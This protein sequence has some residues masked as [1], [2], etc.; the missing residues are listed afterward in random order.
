MDIKKNIIIVFAAT[1]LSGCSSVG[2]MRNIEPS[3]YVH[4]TDYLNDA[5]E[6]SN[7][8]GSIFLSQGR[9]FT[10][11]DGLKY[12][13][14][15]PNVRCSYDSIEYAV[16]KYCAHKGGKMVQGGRW[17]K[18]N[19]EPLF[20]INYDYDGKHYSVS[21]ENFMAVE[22]GSVQG[23][24]QWLSVAERLGFLS[25]RVLL[26]QKLENEINAKKEAAELQRKTKE[27]NTPVNADVGDLICKEDYEAKPYQ[28]PGTAYYKAYVEKKEKNKLQLR[29]VWHG[30]NGFVINDIT[31][32]NNII[33]SSPNGWKHCN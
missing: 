11:T 12:Q 7:C 10:D 21:K 14:N 2:N 31:P 3:K 4:V 9:I 22:Q 30:G 20:Y 24:Q 19:D 13:L 1:L 26:Q 16:E 25:K 18:V 27:K 17:C 6:K 33:W 23:R 5:F 8:V 15:W 28:Y 29:L 32:S